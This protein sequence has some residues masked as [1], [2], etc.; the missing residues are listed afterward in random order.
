MHCWGRFLVDNDGRLRSKLN[1]TAYVVASWDKSAYLS[2]ICNGM[3]C[4]RGW[5][6]CDVASRGNQG[7][8]SY[9]KE[10]SGKNRGSEDHIVR[11]LAITALSSGQSATEGSK[12]YP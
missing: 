1:E 6:G 12:R 2:R 8:E 11:K 4:E 10:E 9:I 5:L 7:Q 3:P